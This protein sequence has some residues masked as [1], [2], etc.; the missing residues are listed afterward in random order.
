MM[1][2]RIALNGT[3]VTSAVKHSQCLTTQATQV[4]PDKTNF[5]IDTPIDVGTVIAIVL[6]SD[7]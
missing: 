3:V 2:S 7:P 1:G 4:S 5:H 6:G